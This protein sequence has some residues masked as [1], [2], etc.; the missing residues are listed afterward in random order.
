M[1]AAV[2]ALAAFPAAQERLPAALWQFCGPG[3]AE[4]ELRKRKGKQWPG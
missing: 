1:L 3:G 2:K 4:P